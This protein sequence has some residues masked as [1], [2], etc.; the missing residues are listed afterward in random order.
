M[1]ENLTLTAADV[2]KL[3]QYLGKL[4]E[5][6]QQEPQRMT[7]EEWGKVWPQLQ[8]GEIPAEYRDRIGYRP[9]KEDST[10]DQTQPGYFDHK[11]ER[12]NAER[13]RVEKKYRAVVLKAIQYALQT[14]TTED[15]QQLRE[16]L[17]AIVDSR[18]ISPAAAR[19]A[20]EELLTRPF[21]AMLQDA[22][23]NDITQIS[24]RGLQIDN[25]TKSVT[26][27]AKDGR[28]IKIEHFDE[29]QN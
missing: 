22:P 9:V 23:I 3:R 10:G 17:Q 16:L 2:A 14:Q 27:T 8:K 7:S 4:D 6:A 15:G 24:T 28:R 1:A 12:W 11:W 21:I 29:L 5:I 20:T 25:F 26:I 19:A 18:D 13:L